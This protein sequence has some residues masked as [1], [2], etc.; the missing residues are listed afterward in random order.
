MSL[1]FKVVLMEVKWDFSQIFQQKS[2]QLGTKGLKTKIS[3]FG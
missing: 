1:S 3:L 2:A